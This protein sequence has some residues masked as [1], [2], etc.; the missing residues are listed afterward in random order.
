MSRVKRN[1]R[2]AVDVVLETPLA[3]SEYAAA[4]L[5]AKRIVD[6]RFQRRYDAL[7]SSAVAVAKRPNETNFVVAIQ[8]FDVKVRRRF[9]GEL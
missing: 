3:T 8:D 9:R 6:P 5:H 1:R 2:G 4:R 7:V